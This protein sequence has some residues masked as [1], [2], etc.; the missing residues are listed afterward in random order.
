MTLIH[1]GHE[2]HQEENIFV[3][4]HWLFAIVWLESK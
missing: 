4:D 3:I 2:E 1:E